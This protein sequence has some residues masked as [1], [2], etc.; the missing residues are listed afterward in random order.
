[1]ATPALP[2]HGTSMAWDIPAE[3]HDAPPT[4]DAAVAAAE[5]GKA[6]KQLGAKQ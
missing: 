6:V 5:E 3:A 2:L 1:M 4:F